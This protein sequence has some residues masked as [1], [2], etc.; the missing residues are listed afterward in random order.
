MDSRQIEDRAAEWLV[1]RDGATEAGTWSGADQRALD[2]WLAESTAHLVAFLR[3]EAAWRR[4]ERL[5]P[6]GAGMPVGEVPAPD[7]WQLAPVRPGEASGLPEP[8]K[9]SKTTLGARWRPGVRWALAASLVLAVA[10]AATW[11]LLSAGTVYRTSIGGL[12]SIPMPDGS[13]VTLNSASE[14]RIRMTP[15][16]RQ[17]FLDHGEAYFEVMRDPSRSFVVV[18]GTQRVVAVG[19]AFSVRRGPEGLRVVVTEGKVKLESAT[20][21]PLPRVLAGKAD[22]DPAVALAAGSMAE[23]RRGR[24]VP[25]QRTLAHAEDEVSWRTGYLIFHDTR[26]VDAIEEFNRYNV[27]KIVIDDADLD[28]IRLSGKFQAT[29]YE[30]FV[31]LLERDFSVRA[32]HSERGVSLSAR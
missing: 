32:S 18:A 16:E 19:T 7:A 5:K 4:A 14:V 23:I 24:D 20:R 21:L 31:R 17:V 22:A 10:A 1:R 15:K 2:G 8:A 27:R 9:A 11:P 29:E 26:L 13:R 3:L 25:D 30:A 6:L 28:R 12:A